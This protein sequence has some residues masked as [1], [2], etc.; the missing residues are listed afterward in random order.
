MIG[1]H[2]YLN[3]DLSVINISALII[4]KLRE[5]VWLKYDELLGAVVSALG[6]NAKE[7]FPSALSFLFL[8]GKVAY[9][10]ELDAFRLDETE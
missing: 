7:V 1:A 9:H 8:L 2:K 5:N 10:L 4:A 6:E 3:L